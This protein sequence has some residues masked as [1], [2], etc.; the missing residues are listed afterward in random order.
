[1]LHPSHAAFPTREGLARVG[2]RLQPGGVFALW[3]DDPPD[4]GFTALLRQGFADCRAEVV[5]FANP[6]TGGSSA[7]TVYVATT[8]AG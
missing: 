3:S 2:A 6:L 8:P 5:S 7:N 1:M 4:D